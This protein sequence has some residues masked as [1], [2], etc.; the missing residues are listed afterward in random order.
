M[1]PGGTAFGLLVAIVV[2]FRPAVP[3][4]WGDRPSWNLRFARST[5]EGRPWRVVKRGT[6]GS[7]AIVDLNVATGFPSR[8][9]QRPLER[10]NIALTFG[11]ILWSRYQYANALFALALLRLHSEWPRRCRSDARDELAPLHLSSRVRSCI[12]YH[13][14]KGRLATRCPAW[15]KSRDL[16]ALRSLLIC[17]K[18][19]T[20]ERNEA[21]WGWPLLPACQ[22]T[23]CGCKL[24]F[25]DSRSEPAVVD[26]C[27]QRF[28]MIERWLR[29]SMRS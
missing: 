21:S 7:P 14:E 8:L 13:T 25:I 29:L 23:A 24:A 18:P 22:K 15:G 28:W 3:V 5:L 11:V 27:S 20:F 19:Q 10:H 26:H 4:I 12:S 1:K 6:A 16:A 9:L 2:S 17:P